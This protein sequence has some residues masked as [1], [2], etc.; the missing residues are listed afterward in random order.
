MHVRM[1]V[2]YL[3]THSEQLSL[4]ICE[5]AIEAFTLA[6]T[7]TNELHICF[8]DSN[9][10][11]LGLYTLPIGQKV[12]LFTVILR[13]TILICVLIHIILLGILL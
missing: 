5:R 2:R 12:W 1:A 9:L 11:I 10:R 3:L 13:K 6:A 8:F 4:P 7:D